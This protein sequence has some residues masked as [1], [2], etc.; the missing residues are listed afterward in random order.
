MKI[1]TLKNVGY[2]AF[3]YILS[4]LAA[5]LIMLMMLWGPILKNNNDL[6]FRALLFMICSTVILFLSLSL[7]KIYGYLK[8]LFIW[9]DNIIICLLFFFINWNVYGMIPFNVSRSN[10]VIILGYL[11]KNDGVPQSKNNIKIY[12][13]TKYFDEYDST[14]TRLREQIAAGNVVEINGKFAITEQGIFIADF[15]KKTASLYNIKNNFLD[16]L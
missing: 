16:N 6:F 11:Y 12:T 2:I 1:N 15:L 5:T 7:L 9:R 13:Q 14:G 4:I 3:I 8:P 10:S